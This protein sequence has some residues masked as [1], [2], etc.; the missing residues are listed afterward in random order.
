MVIVKKRAYSWLKKK[1][2][3][4]TSLVF[5][6]VLLHFFSASSPLLLRFSF[7]FKGSRANKERRRSEERA[8]LVRTWGNEKV[9][10]WFKSF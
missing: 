4:R 10:E 9:I 8:D 6:R 1:V 7:A 5:K 2:L 3:Y